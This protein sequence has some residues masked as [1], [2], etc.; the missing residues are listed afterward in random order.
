MH[1]ISRKQSYRCL[2]TRKWTH[3][4][5]LEFSEPT[6]RERVQFVGLAS[7]DVRSSASYE[8]AVHW[9]TFIIG[10]LSATTE[11]RSASIDELKEHITETIT[12]W[13][14]H[15]TSTERQS[16]TSRGSMPGPGTC[17]HNVVPRFPPRQGCRRG[18]FLRE[19]NA[20]WYEETGHH[21][22]TNLPMS[23][24]SVKLHAN[25]ANLEEVYYF[26]AESQM[27]PSS[28]EQDHTTS[29]KYLT[30]NQSYMDWNPR[31]AYHLARRREPIVASID[32]DIYK[33]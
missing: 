18:I 2:Q 7:S 19:P 8:R 33:R 21:W 1:W 23:N 5:L 9:H 17:R 16:L 4:H 20:Q 14:T 24:R 30:S 32:R 12:T 11:L 10:P 25:E 27:W 3:L 28:P 6:R 15:F 29:H 31:R 26:E 13:S 22:N